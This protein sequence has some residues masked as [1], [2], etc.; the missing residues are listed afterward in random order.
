MR[1]ANPFDERPAQA[2]AAAGGA[3]EAVPLEPEPEPGF[4][5]GGDAP[6][7]ASL[8]E[9]IVG[10]APRYAGLIFDV[11]R[12]DVTL[13]SGAPAERDVVRHPGA[14]AVLAVTDDGAIYL[15]RQYR[16]ALDRVTVEI[17]AGKLD[18]GEDPLCAAQRELAEETGLEAASMARILTI[19]TSVGFSDELIHLYLA[20]GLTRGASHPDE[21]EFLNVDV[22]P[23]GEFVDA[24]LDGQVEDAKTVVGALALDA[25]S[26]RLA[27]G[28]PL[29]TLA[30]EVVV[31]SVEGA[32]GPEAEA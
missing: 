18:P 3:A 4:V 21:D 8:E 24:V 14:V 1:N 19:A 20:T 32:A 28:E 13:P 26:R 29:D 22:V 2:A 10:E 27:P 6:G 31:E 25:I 30:A 17:P 7:D 9:H 15:V 16:V 5:R 12:I 23:V 11:D